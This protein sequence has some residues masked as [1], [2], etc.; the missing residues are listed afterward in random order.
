[1]SEDKKFNRALVMLQGNQEKHE[2]RLDTG[3]DANFILLELATALKLDMKSCKEDF[4]VG[5]GS[6]LRVDKVASISFQIMTEK[7]T[8][9]EPYT[10][11]FF[12][13]DKTTG[14]CK[15]TL[16]TTLCKQIQILKRNQYYAVMERKQTKGKKAKEL[17]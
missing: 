12:V 10:A 3:A 6:K 5:D 9:T 2:A 17:F 1:M 8:Y 11:D 14:G 15:V 13:T 4:I 16:G 7:K